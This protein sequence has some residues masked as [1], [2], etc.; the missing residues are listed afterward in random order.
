[1]IDQH[2]KENLGYGQ[3][4]EICWKS[5]MIMKGYI[6]NPEATADV[7]RDGWLHSGD[8]GY[9]D[10]DGDLFYVGRIKEIIKYQGIQVY[11]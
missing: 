11:N 9:Y 1:M 2:T 4:G 5:P 3:I 7:V 10:M 6:N 8:L